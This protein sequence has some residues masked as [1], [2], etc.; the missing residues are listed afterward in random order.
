MKREMNILINRR[1]NILKYIFNNPNIT[2]KQLAELCEVSTITINRDLNFLKTNGQISK[3]Y[4]KIS[5]LSS[6]L[7]PPL[8]SRTTNK[9]NNIAKF[10]ATLIEN[11]DVI[12]INSSSTALAMLKYITATHVTIITNNANIINTP[13]PPLTSIVLTGGELRDTKGVLIGDFA[14][15]MLKKITV[16]KSFLGCSGIS[17]EA[18]FTTENFNEVSINDLMSKNSNAKVYI[19]ANADKIGYTSNFSSCS[20]QRISNIITN[21]T[22]SNKLVKPFEDLG[23]NILYAPTLIE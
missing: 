22:V 13:H 10:A 9:N 8:T 15:N 17:L 21:D 7:E 6:Q 16:K 14:T 20:I 3:S 19:L 5:I 4:G 1:Q 23:I 11:N 12:F 18:G 2:T